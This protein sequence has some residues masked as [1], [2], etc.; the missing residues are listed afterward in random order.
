MIGSNPWTYEVIDLATGIAPVGVT[1]V[2]NTNQDAET[3]GKARFS[4]IDF[5][6]E[7]SDTAL[8][9]TTKTI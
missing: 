8:V 5:T 9:G 3:I 1:P 7:S 4:V 2:F 6:I